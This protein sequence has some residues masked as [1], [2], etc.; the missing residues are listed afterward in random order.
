MHGVCRRLQESLYAHYAEAA[1]GGRA[2][3]AAGPEP[4]KAGKLK[5]A[6]RVK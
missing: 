6:A 4:N 2:E 3:A 1:A 5:K